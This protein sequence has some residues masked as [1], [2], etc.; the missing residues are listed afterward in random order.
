MEVVLN[1]STNRYLLSNICNL[2]EIPLPF[3][4]LSRRMYDMIGNKTVWVKETKSGWDKRQ[5]S[6]VLCV[7]AD[8]VNRVPPMI[9]F[10]GKGNVLIRESPEYHPGIIVEFNDTAYMNDALFL[11]YIE[12][13]LLPA[14]DGR[15]IL[16]ALDKCTSHCTPAVMNFFRQN[17]ILP[18]LIPAGCTSLIQ[19][20]DFLLINLLKN[21]YGS[22]QMK[23]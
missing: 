15:S 3:E 9:I 22:L 23:L 19:P 18:S 12:L 13:Y 17:H 4:Y 10:H 21:A 11:K 20:L 1:R 5:A 7:F 14:L 6:L 16:F 2:D 8:G